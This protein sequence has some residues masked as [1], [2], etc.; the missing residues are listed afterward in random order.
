MKALFHSLIGKVL[1]LPPHEE[2][3]YRRDEIP[4]PSD[5]GF[6]DSMGEPV[7]QLADGRLP[8][9]DGSC[10]HSRTYK[11]MVGFHRDKVNPDSLE[12]CFEHL[13]RDSPGLYTV[14]C[15]ITIGGIMAISSLKTKK[16]DIIIKSFLAGAIVGAIF[17]ALTAEW[18]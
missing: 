8:L 17:G 6:K 10:I 9:R 5:M 12:K 3:L 7:G 16:K 18:E 2:I 13:R 11:K 15:G 1:S 4:D 14:S